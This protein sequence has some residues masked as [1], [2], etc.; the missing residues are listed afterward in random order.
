MLRCIVA[1]YITAELHTHIGAL[2]PS[3]INLIIIT[4]CVIIL[5]GIIWIAGY[6]TYHV[7]I[8]ALC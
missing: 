5:K 1:N 7:T 6:F 2:I 4:I 8:K 3:L